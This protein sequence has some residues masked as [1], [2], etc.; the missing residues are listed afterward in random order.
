MKAYLVSLAEESDSVIEPAFGYSEPTVCCG[1]P[2]GDVE[3][4]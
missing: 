4:L 3:W 1:L 2:T